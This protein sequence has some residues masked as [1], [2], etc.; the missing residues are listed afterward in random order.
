MA[1]K[2]NRE[3]YDKVFTDLEKFKEFCSSA[4]TLGFN[5]SFRWDEK[6]LYNMKSSEWRAYQNY[7]KFGK[8][9]KPRKDRFKK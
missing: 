6:N 7:L 4:W 5:Y 8:P 9:P 2:Y 1:I 3:A